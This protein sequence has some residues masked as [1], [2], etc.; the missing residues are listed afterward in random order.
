MTADSVR[1][2]KSPDCVTRTIAGESV[3]VPVRNRVGNLDSVYTLNEVGTVIW[4]RIDG[5]R[6]ADDLVETVCELF[7]VT[8]EVAAADVAE[9]LD[10][11]IDAGLVRPE[12]AS[13]RE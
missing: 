3:I 6:T 12:A 5:T 13:E 2:I 10:E 9:F 4:D 1:L 7:E 8:F 11:L